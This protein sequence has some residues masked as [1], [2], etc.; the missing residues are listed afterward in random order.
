MPDTPLT[1]VHLSPRDLAGAKISGLKRLPFEKGLLSG[2]GALESAALSA[3]PFDRLVGSW[4]AQAPAGCAVEMQAQVRSGGA[5]S[6]WFRLSRWREGAAASF[7]PQA[8]DWGCVDADTLKLAKTADAF[9]YR[10]LMEG[11]KGAK[12]PRLR[13]IAVTTDDSSSPRL[14]SPPFSP[15]PWVRELP[16]SPRSQHEAPEELRGNICSPTALAMVLEFWGRKVSTEQAAALVRDHGADIYG[17]WTLNVAGASSLGLAG[18]AA[19]L[20]SLGALQEEIAA[21]RPAVVSMTFAEGEL[22][23]APIPQTRGHLLAVAGFTPDGD[24]IAYDPAAPERSS[25]RRVYRRA[26]FEKAWLERKRGLSYLLA[27]RFPEELQTAAETAD[28]RASPKEPSKPGLMD[29]SLGTQL[30]YGERVRAL[31]ARGNW[32]RVEALEQ[33]H[34]GEDGRWG[35]YPGWVRSESL[36]KGLRPYRADAVLRAKR[37]EIKDSN[38]FAGLTLPLGARVVLLPRRPAG[39]LARRWDGA[40]VRVVSKAPQDNILLPDGR[41]VP[42]EDS[43]L[44][45]STAAAVDRREILEAAAL[46]LGDLY[47]W[48]GRSSL[49][50]KPGWGVDCSGLSNLSYRS[51]G[52]E[53]PRDARDQFLRSRRLRREELKPGDLVFLSETEKSEGVDHVMLYAGSD[54]LIESRFSAGKTLRTTFPERF[55]APL[56]GIESGDVV[57]DLSGAKPLKRRIFFGG[58]LP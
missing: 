16:L 18:E 15:G 31:E 27:E 3:F 43:H 52:I 10:I 45:P 11:G 32:V 22:S 42:V 48:G 35:G 19:W 44:R 28:L 50:K 13:R 17:N 21:G 36:F 23:G 4:N 54:G 7:G 37:T 58:F 30:L 25:V 2:E 49:Q 29:R 47:L 5:W 24:I 39:A 34:C 14:M 40:Q 9:R 20:N 38:G 53:I 51:V 46:F 1:V 41:V 6:K 12:A 33:E 55:G 57:Q 56:S 8:D 26:E